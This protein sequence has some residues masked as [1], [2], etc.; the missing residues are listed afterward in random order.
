MS[1]TLP[2]IGA[3]LLA[4]M[5]LF[6]A[7]TGVPGRE[8]TPKEPGSSLAEAENPQLLQP[9]LVYEYSLVATSNP[10]GA[11][12]RPTWVLWVPVAHSSLCRARFLGTNSPWNVGTKRQ[13][14]TFLGS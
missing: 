11:S 10:R 13:A 4:E 7:R 2:A 9:S 3:Q 12:P 1:S 5:P 8:R 6:S 14:C